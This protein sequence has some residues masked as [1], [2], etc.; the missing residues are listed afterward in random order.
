MVI[1]IMLKVYGVLIY[2]GDLFVIGILDVIKLDFGDS[3]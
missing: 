3:V 2:M 1:G